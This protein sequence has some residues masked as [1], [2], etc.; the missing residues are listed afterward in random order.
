MSEEDIVKVLDS[1]NDE[2][3]ALHE[4]HK[5]LKA[6]LA[7]LKSKVYLTPEE[8][9]EKKNIQKLKLAKKDRMA[10]LISDYRKSHA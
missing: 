8:E 5:D 9:I 7:E 3:K 10:A 4:E 1:D 6:K 2:F